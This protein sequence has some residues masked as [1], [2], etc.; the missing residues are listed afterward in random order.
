MY[1]RPIP[2]APPVTMATRPSSLMR[3]PFASSALRHAIGAPVRRDDFRRFRSVADADVI[4]MEPRGGRPMHDLLPTA[5]RLGAAD[6]RAGRQPRSAPADALRRLHRSATCSITSGAW[7]SHSPK[8][9]ARSRAPTRRR[10]HG[11]GSVRVPAS[12]CGLIGATPSPG[13]V[14][15]RTRAGQRLLPRP[16]STASSAD[17]ERDAAASLARSSA[18][19]TRSA[20]WP[21]RPAGDPRPAPPAPI[22]ADS[23]W[24]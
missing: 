12:F 17:T 2:R 20:S 24:R 1:A 7:R 11:A 9:P 23:V 19:T 10:H 5:R 21:G 18:G 3:S 15:L 22:R 14:A 8:R 13:L 16:A 4:W 6:R